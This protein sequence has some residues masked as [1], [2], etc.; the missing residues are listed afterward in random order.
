MFDLTA[1][2][3]TETRPFSLSLLS[4]AS[5]KPLPKCDSIVDILD[6]IK[7]GERKWS[8]ED[9]IK[10]ALELMR[11]EALPDTMAMV[12][13][14]IKK[15]QLPSRF[16][17]SKCHVPFIPLSPDRAC[18]IL[19]KFSHVIL[20]GDSLVRH[21][22]QTL[23]MILRG[24]WTNGAEMTNNPATLA[25]CACDGQY[26]EQAGCRIFDPYFE[27]TDFAYTIPKINT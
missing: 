15:E 1:A 13:H 20:D 4:V 26:S 2:A 16:A 3:K 8:E 24:E 9:E 10:F 23:I 21:F 11:L 25:H 18:E 22:R 17:P 5:A 6:S 14:D 12:E 27:R 7:N 19:N